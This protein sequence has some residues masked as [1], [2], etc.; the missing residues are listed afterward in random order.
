MDTRKL[1]HGKQNGLFAGVDA[2]VLLGGAVDPC[3]LGRIADLKPIHDIHE[4]V[5]KKARKTTYLEG[6][7]EP[8]PG[9]TFCLEPLPKFT[10]LCL[11]LRV[12]IVPTR[13]G[14]A[15]HRVLVIDVEPDKL[16]HV[17]SPVQLGNGV[18]N[19]YILPAAARL[20]FHSLS[21]FRS[22]DRRRH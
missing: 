4:T 18:V 15:G 12:A 7:M 21:R 13:L 6:Q 2:I 11:Q 22:R 9:L 16:V 10:Y 8:I 14:D 1:V 20:R 5:V 3:Q 19:P 17:E